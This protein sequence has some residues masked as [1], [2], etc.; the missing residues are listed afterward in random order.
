MEDGAVLGY[1]LAALHSKDQLPSA[2]K[3]YERL[4]KTRGET[5]A[6][7]TFAQRDDFHMPDGPQQEARDALMLSKLGKPIDCKFPARWQCPIAQPWL[8]GYDA[9]KEVEQALHE[10]PLE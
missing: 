4:R 1:I 2:L 3:L 7:E 8:Y 10:W 6:R 5:I 9:E